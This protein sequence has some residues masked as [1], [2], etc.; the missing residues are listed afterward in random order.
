MCCAMPPPLSEQKHAG[1]LV[2]EESPRWVRVRFG[3]DTIADST[4]PLL[5]WEEGRVVPFYLF[6]REAVCG[7]MLSEAGSEGSRQY[8]DLPGAARAAWSYPGADGLAGHVAFDWRAMDGW[9]EEEEEV[10]VHARD[11]HKRV[12]VLESSRH[13]VVSI[14]GVV[15]ADTHRP[16][17]LFETG[18]PTRYYIPPEDVRMDLMRPTEKHTKCPYKGTASYLSSET[19]ADV[20]W[21]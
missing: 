7:E 20:A 4:H 19:E 2:Y 16:R 17:L 13:V 3:G 6:P 18:L 11:P 10:F 12:D 15:V 1:P 9:Y 8:Y 14:D 21:F 5:A